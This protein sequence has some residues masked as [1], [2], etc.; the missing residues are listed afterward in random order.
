[1]K[2]YGKNSLSSIINVILSIVL[3]LGIILSGYI[4]FFELPKV[5]ISGFH[6]YITIALL[7]IG[8]IA[9]F[10]F[11]IELKRI[12][13]TLVLEN[14]FTISNVKS[15]RRLMF[16]CFTIAFCYIVN[17][18]LNLGKDTFS[19]IN[20][21]QAGIHTDAEIFIFLLAG[22]FIGILSKVFEQAVKYKEDNDL[23][24]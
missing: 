1:M 6:K 22:C 10:A 12:I 24:I 2:Y 7:I 19:I 16:S 18:V 4:L 13:K 23:T 5:N 21:D 11:I 20:I 15:L 8:I 14:P 3:I 17:F 9:T